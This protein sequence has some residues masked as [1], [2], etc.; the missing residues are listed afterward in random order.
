M[1]SEIA[2]R[3]DFVHREVA[4]MVCSALT[5]NSSARVSLTPRSPPVATRSC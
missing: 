1:V 2:V 5:G 3:H 4:L